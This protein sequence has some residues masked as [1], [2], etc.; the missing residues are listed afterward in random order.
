MATYRPGQ[1]LAV[2]SADKL[3]ARA[4]AAELCKV[5]GERTEE[6]GLNCASIDDSKQWNALLGAGIGNRKKARC[7]ECTKPLPEDH[8]PA[9]GP[10]CPACAPPPRQRRPW[11]DDAQTVNTSKV[12][13]DET[14]PDEDIQFG[15]L[16]RPGICKRCAEEHRQRDREEAKAKKEIREQA[17]ERALEEGTLEAPERVT[18]S[19]GERPFGMTPSKAE[20]VGYLV[21]KV[22]EGKPASKAKVR[23]GWRIAD[24]AG[25]SCEGLDLEAV[26]TLLKPAALPVAVTF[27][28]L[29]GNGDFCTACQRVQVWALFSRKMRTKPPDARRCIACVEASGVEKEAEGEAGSMAAVGAVGR[30]NGGRTGKD[31]GYGG[32]GSGRK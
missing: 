7:S 19:L 28:T 30:T 22:S 17:R 5:C 21:A 25:T 10:F 4:K 18:V 2:G 23:P 15:H 31:G 14:T 8:D 32:R 12:E 11:I 1:G 3:R 20:G 27:E 16:V 29:P 6:G 9:L 24:V 26:Q 13:A